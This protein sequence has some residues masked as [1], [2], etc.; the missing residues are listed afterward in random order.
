M[1]SCCC[2]CLLL[3]VPPS[4]PH[5]M[6]SLSLLKSIFQTIKSAPGTGSQAGREAC[7]ILRLSNWRWPISE[8]IATTGEMQHA[9]SCVATL[10]LAPFSLRAVAFTAAESSINCIVERKTKR[11]REGGAYTVTMPHPSAPLSLDLVRVLGQ[12]NEIYVYYRRWRCA[13]RPFLGKWLQGRRHS[14]IKGK[15]RK[16]ACVASRLSG[17]AGSGL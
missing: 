16:F 17:S 12:S 13:S 4:L 10:P 9:A 2:C 11:D 6:S 3:P 5:T 8:L 14:R 15:L 1:A 7:S